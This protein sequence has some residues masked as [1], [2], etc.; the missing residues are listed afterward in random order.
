MEV[1]HKIKALKSLTSKPAGVLLGHWYDSETPIKW[2][3]DRWFNLP[4]ATITTSD[5]NRLYDAIKASES[6]SI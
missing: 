3:V 6:G 5:R 4:M 2:S 1:K